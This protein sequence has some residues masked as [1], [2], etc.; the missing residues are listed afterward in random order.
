MSL[1]H[2]FRGKCF[3]EWEWEMLTPC[4]MI[5]YVRKLHF[6]ARQI[7]THPTL[8]LPKKSP[9]S[10]ESREGRLNSSVPKNKA[11]ELMI[12]LWITKSFIHGQKAFETEVVIV[13][14]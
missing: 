9:N 2:L 10:L 4:K 6:T 7:S 8:Q 1:V 11:G 12:C 14:S 5:C 13:I 3:D